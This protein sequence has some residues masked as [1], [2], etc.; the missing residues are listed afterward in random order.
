M[1]VS[2]ARKDEAREK[3]K[4]GYKLNDP[5]LPSRRLLKSVARLINR[6]DRWGW[7]RAAENK[8]VTVGRGRSERKPR[9]EVREE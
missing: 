3:K 7:R 2:I 6:T 1:C 5:C 9:E 4:R 8:E